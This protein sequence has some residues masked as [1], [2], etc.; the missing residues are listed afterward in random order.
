VGPR[1]GG[2]LRWIAAISGLANPPYP[3]LIGDFRLEIADWGRPI[4]DFGLRIADW[5]FDRKRCQ[6][7]FA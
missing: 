3:S 1:I 6:D 2:A 7:D 5:K 4:A